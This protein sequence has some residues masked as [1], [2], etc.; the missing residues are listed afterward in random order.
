MIVLVSVPVLSDEFRHSFKEMSFFIDDKKATNLT[1][2]QFLNLY[3]PGDKSNLAFRP[4]ISNKINIK[5]KIY[6][7][8]NIGQVQLQT[9]L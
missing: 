1:I 9:F 6:D 3:L 5:Q 8:I 4:S 2:E 7:K